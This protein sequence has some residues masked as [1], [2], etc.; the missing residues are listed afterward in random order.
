MVSPLSALQPLPPPHL[1]QPAHIAPESPPVLR[2][3]KKTQQRLPRHLRRRDTGVGFQTPRIIMP[4]P[5][6]RWPERPGHDRSEEQTSELQSLTN[7]VC[8]LLLEKINPST[9][10]A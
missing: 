1:P 3:P 8:R 5:L 6:T 10:S 2:L 4:R 9:V 7:L